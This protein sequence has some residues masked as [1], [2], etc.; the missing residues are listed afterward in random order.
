MG[1]GGQAPASWA[2]ATRTFPRELSWA[3]PVGEG[4]AVQGW[5]R[6]PGPT[7]P[8][9]RWDYVGHGGRVGHPGPQ[10]DLCFSL[11]C[12]DSEPFLGQLRIV[13]GHFPPPSDWGQEADGFSNCEVRAC[14]VSGTLLGTR[15]SEVNKKRQ[16]RILM[17]LTPWLGEG[18]IVYTTVWGWER[19]GP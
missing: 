7:P 6:G 4:L 10:S 18:A 14:A 3:N 17:R 19:A 12:P 15:N 2:G 1:G 11:G 16:N 8:A 13:R 5:L 9:R